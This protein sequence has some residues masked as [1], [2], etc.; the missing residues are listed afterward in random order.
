MMICIFTALRRE[1]HGRKWSLLW[2]SW[3]KFHSKSLVQHTCY[4]AQ[5]IHTGVLLW[6]W[7]SHCAETFSEGALVVISVFVLKQYYLWG[8][9]CFLYT[10]SAAAAMHNLILMHFNIQ[11]AWSTSQTAATAEY[12]GKYST[13]KDVQG[14]HCAR[15]VCNCD[16]KGILASPRISR[17]PLQALSFPF[18]CL[19]FTRQKRCG[20]RRS[21]VKSQ[22]R[23]APHK[24]DLYTGSLG[25]ALV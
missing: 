6:Q 12:D 11:N 10:A 20:S 14:K 13:H 5:L 8:L 23:Q 3:W 22:P 19:T 17:E 2:L 25:E 24:E 1:V 15:F 9:L 16:S 21:R 18:I 7:Q 4:K